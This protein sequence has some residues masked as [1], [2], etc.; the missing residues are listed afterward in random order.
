MT[1]FGEIK[2]VDIRNIWP[3]E[4]TD[5]TPWLV[6]NIDRL[7]RALGMEIEVQDREADVGDFSLD[8]LAKDLGTGRTVVI[9]NQLTQTDHDHLGKLLTYAG[10]FDAGVLVWIAK[11]LRDE[12]RQA[13]EWLNEQTRPDVDFFGVVLEVIRIDDSKPAFNF[14][15]VVFPNEWQ[16][17]KGGGRRPPGAS[18]K[19]EA[20]RAY[21]QRLIDE[22]RTKYKFTG[23]KAGQP[24]SWYSFSSGVRGVI[25]SNSFAQGGK[26]RAE[27]YIDLQDKDQN[28]KLFD[29][30]LEQKAEIEKEYGIGLAWERLDDKRASR[31]A[32]Y[33]EGSIDAS[34]E[35]QVELMQWSI[36]NMLRLKK[37][38]LPKA[39]A[40]LGNTHV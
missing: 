5:F 25:F 21:F 26:V 27:V 36:E 19:G 33:R 15:P 1:D 11:E 22:L 39:K 34:A 9:E 30:L 4:A 13:L 14:K 8:I 17:D 18:V 23:A 24:Q 12:H 28:K 29:S 32:A 10:G 16:K 6:D 38:I 20:Y 2:P 35:M 31:I 37:V 40:I 3:N 7:G